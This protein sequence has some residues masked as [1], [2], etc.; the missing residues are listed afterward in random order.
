VH[1]APYASHS[2]VCILAW[3]LS[4]SV[5][6]IIIFDSCDARICRW[7]ALI[8]NSINSAIHYQHYQ[9]NLLAVAQAIPSGQ[10]MA[11]C[12]ITRT[13]TYLAT[14]VPPVLW[15]AVMTNGPSCAHAF[16]GDPISSAQLASTE[17]VRRAYGV[18]SLPL[19]TFKV[20][21]AFNSMQYNVHRIRSLH[22]SR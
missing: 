9:N 4:T 20:S 8:D 14:R 1:C 7:S 15:S 22:P 12:Q 5:R 11:S 18:N 13:L 2:R 16:R 6:V 10:C 19:M 3:S 21:I 17:I